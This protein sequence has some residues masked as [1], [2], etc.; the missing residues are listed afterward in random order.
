MLTK[1]E[2]QYNLSTRIPNKSYGV[3]L[4]LYNLNKI[5]NL[6]KIRISIKLES[7]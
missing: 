3:E 2:Y 4:H 5:V 1:V 6:K 7:Q